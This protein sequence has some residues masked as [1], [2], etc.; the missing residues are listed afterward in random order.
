MTLKK[1]EILAGRRLMQDFDSTLNSVKVL[2]V[3]TDMLNV[4]RHNMVS[5][6]PWCGLYCILKASH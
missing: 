5:R 1:E 6:Y 2:G 4:L 3:N